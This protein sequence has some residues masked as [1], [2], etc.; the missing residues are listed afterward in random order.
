MEIYGNHAHSPATATYDLYGELNQDMW[1]YLASFMSYTVLRR[2]CLLNSVLFTLFRSL[3]LKRRKLR[4]SVCSIS[5]PLSFYKFAAAYPQS[6]NFLNDGKVVILQQ[7]GSSADDSRKMEIWV[8]SNDRVFQPPIELR[9]EDDPTDFCVMNYKDEVLIA[10]I[11]S[12]SNRIKLLKLCTQEEEGASTRYVIQELRTFGKTGVF[13]ENLLAPLQCTVDQEGDLLVS[14]NHA[15]K[16]FSIPDGN[17]M[18]AVGEPRLKLMQ[19]PF[20]VAVDPLHEGRL[21]IT[22]S[23]LHQVQVWAD[24]NHGGQRYIHREILTQ[25]SCDIYKPIYFYNPFLFILLI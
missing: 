22:D 11:V 15:I 16:S 25:P 19:L 3:C 23:T 9:A 7:A 21:V 13:P 1:I 14:S 5:T 24:L 4:R 10:L 12:H 20:G 2:C 17:F 8:L 18:G 6:I